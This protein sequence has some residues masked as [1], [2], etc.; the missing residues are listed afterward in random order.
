[1]CSFL[2]RGVH[3]YKVSNLV[4]LNILPETLKVTHS[5]LIHVLVPN[6]VHKYKVPYLVVVNILPLTSSVTH[7]ELIHVL[8]PDG[9]HKYKVSNLVVA[10]ILPPTLSVT[11][12]E[13]MQVLVPEEGVLECPLFSTFN[14]EGETGAKGGTTPMGDLGSAELKI[15]LAHKLHVMANIKAMNH[16]AYYKRV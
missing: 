9:V 11:H 15:M 2:R 8:V 1:M 12:S 3:K 5:E 7:S 13:L 6:G 16:K 4:V 10:N 14:M